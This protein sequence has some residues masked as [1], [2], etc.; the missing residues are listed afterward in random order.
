MAKKKNRY[1]KQANKKHFLSGLNEGLPTKGN[2]KNTLLETGKDILI[3]VLGGGLIGAA[4]GR[5]SLLVGIVTTGAGH[6]TGNKLVQLLGVGMMASNGFQKSNTVSGLEGLDG[7]KERLKAYKEAFSEKL[8]LDKIMKK[9]A[10]TAAAN[11]FGE[12]QYFTYPDTSMNGG[13]AALNDIEDQIAE[14]ARQFQGQLRGEE[15]LI[16]D[17]YEVGE[18]EE[19]LY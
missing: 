9:V 10:A 19:R 5:P 13:L 15:E 16:G 14:S 6:Y 3:G 7:V 8:Y 2:T 18:L 1:Q 12:L 17:D 4:I 11:G